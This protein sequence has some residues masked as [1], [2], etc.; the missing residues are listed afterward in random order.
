[1][2]P[3][4]LDGFKQTILSYG[5]NLQNVFKSDQGSQTERILSIF[6]Q[7]TTARLNENDEKDYNY[8]PN[9][10]ISS[11][12]TLINFLPKSLM[13]QFRRLTNV[14]F[15]AIGI[16]ALVGSETAYYD[17][18]VDPEGIL[19]PMAIV[20][21]ISMIKDFVE[22]IKR[23]QADAKVNNRL[24]HG[25]APDGTI[26]RKYWKDIKV[27]DIL[28]I[29]ADEELPAD[30]LVLK[31]CGVSGKNC[32]VETAAID[33]ET[34]LKIKIPSL[35]GLHAA[36]DTKTNF[37]MSHDRSKFNG[38]TDSLRCLITAEPPNSSIHSFNGTIERPDENGIEAK[39]AKKVWLTQKN[40][41]LRGSVLRATDWCIA[42]TIYTGADTKLSLNSKRPPSNIVW[43]DNNNDAAYLCLDEDQQEE[44]FPNGGGCETSYPN[45]GLTFFTFATLYNNFSFFIVSDLELYDEP[46]DTPAECNSSGM[47]ADLGQVQYVLS[48]KTGTLTKNQMVVQCLSIGKRV[49]GQFKGTETTGGQDGTSASDIEADTEF[50]LS[51]GEVQS[52]GRMVDGRMAGAIMKDYEKDLMLHFMRILV[53][54]NTGMIMPAS[55]ENGEASNDDTIQNV[56]DLENRLQAESP[57]EVALIL[58]AAQHCGVLLRSRSSLEIVSQGLGKYFSNPLPSDF[59]ERVEILAVNEFDSDRKMMSIVIRI[60]DSNIDGKQESS[61]MEGKVYLLCKGADSSILRQCADIGGAPYVEYCKTHINLFANTG[62]RTLAAAYR[63]ISRDELSR[64]LA[65]YEKASTT[66]TGRSEAMHKAAQDIEQNMILLGALGIEDELQD[67]VPEAIG[68]MHAAGINVWMITGDKA[69]TAIAI[70]KKCALVKPEKHQIERVLNLSDEPLRERIKQLHEYVLKLSRG[71][72]PVASALSDEVQPSLKIK[73][74]TGSSNGSAGKAKKQ[75]LALIID[76][77]S[78]EKLWAIE[79]L[80]F[81]PVVI[82]CRVSPLQKAALACMVKTAPGNPVTLGIGDGANDVGMIHESRVGVGISGREGRH[83]AN[84]A[85]FAVAQFR[86]ITILLFHHGRYNYIRCSKL[87]LYSFYKNL[88]LVSVL[89]YYC[90]Y[91]GFSGTVPVESLVFSGFNFYLGCPVLAIGSMD[92]DVPRSEILKFPFEAYATGRLGEMLNIK[93]MMRW[94]IHAFVQ[95]LLVFV[96]T[97]RFISGPTWVFPEDGYWR[98]DMYGTGFNHVGSGTELGLYPSGLLIFTVIVIAMQFK[99]L[100]MAVTPNMIFWTLWVLS[101]MGYF[102]FIWFYGLFSYIDWFDV[103]GMSFAQPYFW[104]ALVIVI[105]M[106]GI[107]DHVAYVVWEKLDPSYSELLARKLANLNSVKPDENDTMV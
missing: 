8:P 54:C 53:Y 17:T 23:H 40:F 91:S 59:E 57:D 100:N 21:L 83:A 71:D 31:S 74:N 27:G 10:I 34:N 7:P 60:L 86:F 61:S 48:D 19:A 95:G 41:M 92:F 46:T 11:R 75:E 66:I 55:N 89:F 14:Y 32:Y 5:K 4:W 90:A 98:F 62:L 104:L 20:V 58:A 1:M 3:S 70:G 93:N 30:V 13:E 99:V 47:C 16:I 22:D 56:K 88:L 49:Y 18:A 101:I 80:K 50:Y 51:I 12:Y 73:G 29:F 39:D 103:G 43:Q 87:I 82:A 72:I 24:T 44:R 33:G 67:G 42:A 77:L 68:L 64:W 26:F 37:E 97:T 94:S 45:S 81:V 6:P 79:E 78:L 35:S 102:L 85:D 15:L 84:A 105:I 65:V 9:I 38:T 2:I 36:A 76:G 63:E 25:L 69:E 107:T 28:V 52:V 96:V 106:L